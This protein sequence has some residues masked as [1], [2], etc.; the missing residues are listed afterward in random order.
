MTEQDNTSQY[1]LGGMAVNCE[2]MT[3]EQYEQSY[4]DHIQ[5]S[6]DTP[7]AEYLVA[8]NYLT[9]EQVNY[10]Q[11]VM[12]GEQAEAPVE[13]A[14][15]D[16]QADQG[17]GA[18]MP[19]E[20]D[21]AD[22][23]ISTSPEDVP[24]PP[25]EGPAAFAEP[26]PAPGIQESD[27]AI[28]VPMPPEEPEAAVPEA[29][30]PA[31][32]PGQEE[33]GVGFDTPMPPETP[34]IPDIS[35]I[36]PGPV[37]GVPPKPEL[38]QAPPAPPGSSV[39]VPPG[40]E[41]EESP[42]INKP[43]ASSFDDT[44]DGEDDTDGFGSGDDMPEK[45][46]LSLEAEPEVSVPP[47]DV[48]SAADNSD[49]SA[50]QPATIEQELPS[51][52]EPEENDEDY[53]DDEGDES[54]GHAVRISADTVISNPMQPDAGPEE[55]SALV[56]TG[57]L[58]LCLP[59]DMIS[60]LKLNEAGKTEITDIDGGTHEY[61]VFGPVT[62]S[63]M[64]RECTVAAVELPYGASPVLGITPLRELGLSLNL[65]DCSLE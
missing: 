59:T 39:P 61:R 43:F 34:D 33:T 16:A 56:S 44:D 50:L 65:D 22:F 46:V 4:Y 49:E 21:D 30:M 24:M 48:E 15:A 47:A 25:D 12:G 57:I 28:D 60:R 55:C 62:C 10:V 38:P 35:D 23:D 26:A 5:N 1:L 14:P 41:P 64:G 53:D 13:T 42:V 51:A 18:P 58:Q 20:E 52:A 32:V 63:V 27:P 2:L 45:K 6:P 11:S 36:P 19:P 3:R 17:M 29:P 54:K 9:Q 8:N 40:D 31:G 7:Y 37:G